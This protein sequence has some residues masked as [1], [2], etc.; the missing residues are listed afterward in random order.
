MAQVCEATMPH[1]CDHVSSVGVSGNADAPPIKSHCAMPRKFTCWLFVMFQS[2]LA[3]CWLYL[4][5]V[6]ELKRKPAVLSSRPGWLRSEERRV[7]KECRSRWSP[8]H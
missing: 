8:Y 2:N 6:G 7:G 3:Q 5:G 1:G 4:S